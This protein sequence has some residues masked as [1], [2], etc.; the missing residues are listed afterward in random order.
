[1][2]TVFDRYTLENPPMFENYLITEMNTKTDI[3]VRKYSIPV[4]FCICKLW[5][6]GERFSRTDVIER[7][8]LFKQYS[9]ATAQLYAAL[10]TSWALKI[11]KK[12]DNEGLGRMAL[13]LYRDPDSKKKYHFMRGQAMWLIEYI[14]SEE[15]KRGIEAAEN[16]AIEEENKSYAEEKPGEALKQYGIIPG[17]GLGLNTTGDDNEEA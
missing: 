9:P 1:M 8:P 11:S 6:L 14:E 10:I 5:K 7:V 15:K 2:S 13:G 17:Q 16:K 12:Y 3:I 4:L